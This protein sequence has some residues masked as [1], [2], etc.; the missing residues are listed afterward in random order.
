MPAQIAF[1]TASGAYD[2]AYAIPCLIFAIEPTTI[3]C[4]TVLSGAG[5]AATPAPPVV[6]VE[7]V[8]EEAVGAGAVPDPPPPPG[9]APPPAAIA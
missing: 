7:V 3:G 6:A 8:F 4:A 1:W 5:P 2:G 9:E